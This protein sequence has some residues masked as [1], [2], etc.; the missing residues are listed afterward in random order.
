MQLVA[1]NWHIYL[2]TGS[3]FALGLTG[4]VRVVPIVGFS[5]MGGLIAD[6]HDRRRVLIIT[7]TT[8][9]LLAGIMGLMTDTGWISVGTI[10]LLSALTAAAGAL[11]TPSWQ[12]IIPNLVPV[13]HLTNA[14]SLNE[15]MRTT[16]MIV[17]PGIAGFVI[18]W[19]GVAAVYWIN[20]ASFVAVII[21]LVLMINPA[22]RNLGAGSISLSALSEGIHFVRHSKI[23]LS[24]TLLDFFGTF[25][26]TASALL[27]IFA[28]EILKVG[29]QGFGIL[30]AA[31]AV[32]A[33]IAGAGMSF[34]GSVKKKGLLVLWAVGIFGTAT[35]VFGMSRWFAVSVFFLA[36]VGAADTVS[37]I[38]RQTIRQVITPDHLRGRMSSVVFIFIQSGP[39]L[40]NLQTGIVATL[41]GAPLSVMA[42][43]VATVITVALIAW[44]VPQLRSYR[45]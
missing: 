28:R 31:R 41:I 45:D 17:G 13:E 19:L 37:T 44:L 7:Q 43:G 4:L 39:Q 21:A 10:Y 15:I 18:A 3:A 9:M 27:P 25:F 30:S 32:G 34:A 40:G 6:R 5:L 42:G 29:P 35:A 20:A 24:T 22:Q 16:A 2:L 1:I 23:L 14:M 36:M 33:V 11:D 8:M 26:S 12:A 38:L